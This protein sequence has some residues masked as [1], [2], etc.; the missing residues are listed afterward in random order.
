MSFI[1]RAMSAHLLLPALLAVAA[2]ACLPATQPAAAGI[3]PTAVSVPEAEALKAQALAWDDAIVHKRRAGIEAN[4]AQDFLHIGGDG[5]LSDRA[6]FLDAILSD[7][8]S[9][10]PYAMENLQVRLFGDTAFVIGTTRMH[11][12]WRGKPFASHYRFTDAYL[13][14]DGAW[15]VAHIQITELPAE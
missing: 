5:R 9:I 15:K 7:A 14:R 11:G 4:M 12:T 6:Q 10:A 2:T 13:R 1:E 8:L 3:A